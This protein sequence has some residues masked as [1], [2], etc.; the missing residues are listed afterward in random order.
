[1]GACFGWPLCATFRS[2]DGLNPHALLHRIVRVHDR[3][4]AFG[5]AGEYFD[6]IAE[7]AAHQDALEVHNVACAYQRH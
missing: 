1:M 6:A 4:L 2:R 5:H 7:V 3:S